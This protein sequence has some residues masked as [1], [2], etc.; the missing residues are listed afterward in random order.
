MICLKR[1]ENG[2]NLQ[3]SGAECGLYVEIIG[4]IKLGCQHPEIGGNVT[5]E[6]KHINIF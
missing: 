1:I 2:L 6:Y 5:A 3:D 4:Q